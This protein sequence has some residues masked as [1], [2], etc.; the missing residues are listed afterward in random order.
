MWRWVGPHWERRRRGESHPVL[1]FLFEYYR[2]RPSQ[3]LRWEPPRPGPLPVTRERAARWILELLERTAQR[4]PQFGCFGLH[5]WAMLYR[6]TARRHPNWPLRLSWAEIDRVVEE[7]GLACTHFDAYRF[8]TPS[9]AVRNRWCLTRAQQETFEQ[10]GCVHA[11]MDLYKW[12]YTFWPWTGSDLVAD[13]FEL[14]V[15][16]REVD[17][18]ASPY[19]LRG[20]GYEPIPV[21]TEA[22]RVL[23]AQH[24]RELWQR[25]QPVRARLIARYRELLGASANRPDAVGAP[26]RAVSAPV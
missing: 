1:D 6:A 26:G 10:P 19:D 12:A 16:A 17:M 25:A 15:A 20:L 13:A 4:P 8:F 3:L 7:V 14:A 22:G 5:E 23:Y 11:T 9:A 2:F 24:Q 18:R 21:E